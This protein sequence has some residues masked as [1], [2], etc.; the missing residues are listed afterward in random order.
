MSSPTRRWGLPAAALVLA[1]NAVGF[2]VA[3]V[4]I[5]ERT[6]ATFFVALTVPTTVAALLA[7]AITAFRGNGPVADFGLPTNLREA[8][9]QLR[10]GLVWGAASVLGGLAIVV[11]L[12]AVSGTTEES[13][14]TEIGLPRGWK[15]AVALW[16]WLVA[17][18]GEELM[19]RGMLWGALEKRSV[20]TGW[21][22]VLGSPWVTLAITAALFAA[23]HGEW[24][25]YIVLLWGGVAIG[26]ARLRTGS[27]FAS[28]TAHSM[29]NLLPA[30]SVLFLPA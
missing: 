24:W 7:L 21:T 4:L 1:V 15:V 5:D 27:V 18:L 11:V 9:A 23:W 25:R 14:L 3:A 13:P 22:R 17:P 26:M 2:V 16:V 12:L 6:A 29:N 30:I 10:V 28:W 8:A 20:S 19:F